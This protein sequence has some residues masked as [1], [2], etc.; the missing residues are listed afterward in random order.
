MD[1][2]RVKNKD[3]IAA[4]KRRRQLATLYG[5]TP[6]QYDEMTATQD[7]RCLLCGKKAKLVVD[8]DHTTGRVR[9]LLC[10]PC[11]TGLGSFSDDADV[12]RR[13]ADYL[14]ANRA[15]ETQAIGI[16]HD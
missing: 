3:R 7:G 14:E 13:A 11:N 4:G 15:S 12:L 9:G 8:H 10:H 6:Q 1:R 2:Y 5:L 16:P